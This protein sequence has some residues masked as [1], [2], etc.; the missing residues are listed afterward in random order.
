MHAVSSPVQ[1]SGLRSDAVRASCR[2]AEEL[3]IPSSLPASLIVAETVLNRGLKDSIEDGALRLALDVHDAAWWQAWG[4]RN[5]TFADVSLKWRVKWNKWPSQL[6]TSGYVI[7]FGP[8]QITPRTALA[9]CAAV[10][11]RNEVCGRATYETLRSLLDPLRSAELAAVVLR[12][13]KDRFCSYTGGR[14]GLSDELL[15]ALYNYGSDIYVL[16]YGSMTHHYRFDRWIVTSGIESSVRA[17]CGLPAPSIPMGRR[18]VS[19]WS[20]LPVRL[21]PEGRR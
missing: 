6:I 11:A 5:K 20:N 17:I 10:R 19:G 3:G 7:S 15:A 14:C 12:Y 1:V 13:E 16:K 4:E 2:A 21:V 8:A 9:A 18:M